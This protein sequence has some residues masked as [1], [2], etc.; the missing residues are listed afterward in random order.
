MLYKD[1]SDG[2]I[3]SVDF[4]KIELLPTFKLH[5]YQAKKDLHE[6]PRIFQNRFRFDKSYMSLEFNIVTSIQIFLN[7]RQIWSR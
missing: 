2:S 4:D 6:M 3:V 1:N 5:L 7:I